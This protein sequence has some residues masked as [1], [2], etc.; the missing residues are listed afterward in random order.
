MN[1]LQL[2]VTLLFVTSLSSMA[3]AESQEQS[4]LFDSSAVLR[5]A[6]DA[7]FDNMC[8]E[9]EDDNCDYTPANLTVW[10]DQ[11]KPKVLPVEVKVR[12]GYRSYRK[13]CQVPPLF[14]RFSS[15]TTLGTPFEGQTLLPLTSHCKDQANKGLMTNLEKKVKPKEY[16]QYVL[17]EYLG[18]RFY[19]LLSDVSLSVRL[20]SIQYT[21][22]GRPGRK[23]KYAF[24]T[25]HFDSLAARKQL[26]RLPRGSFDHQSIDVFAMDRLNLF[27][28]MIGNTDYSVVR[29]R[30]TILLQDEQGKQ[31]PA[32]Y[33]LDFS[34][35]VDADYGSPAPGLPI[36]NNRVRLYLGFCH[37]QLDW[38][39]TYG[40]Y[41]EKRDALF[42]EIRNTPGLSKV[43]NW[44]VSDYLKQFYKI[45]G[46]ETNRKK[47][48]EDQCQSWPP[49]PVDHTTPKEKR[50]L[51]EASPT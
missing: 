42:A 46:S 14:V 39:R 7:D 51:P 3:Q 4:A 35:L 8:R 31:I 26:K 37:P 19:N 20:L 49:S 13:N 25:E 36:Q 50:T 24:F 38:Q 23:P 30:N 10:D 45:L 18:Y 21:G 47:M 15:E 48:I 5:L 44:I 9:R 2:L 29:Q 32:P 6:L 34:G 16:E 11:N 17:K 1:I 22:P 28:F 43:K 40:L 41:A 27:H 12:G 33:D